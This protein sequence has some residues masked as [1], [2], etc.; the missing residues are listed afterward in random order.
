MSHFDR[1]LAEIHRMARADAIEHGCYPDRA[2]E[3]AVAAVRSTVEH[4]LNSPTPVDNPY[5]TFVDYS[6][7]TESILLDDVNEVM[8]EIRRDDTRAHIRGLVGEAIGRDATTVLVKPADFDK[9]VA[10]HRDFR[11]ARARRQVHN[12]TTVSPMI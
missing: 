7:L 10:A 8:L 2:D 9:V 4:V 5:M 6:C 11:R 1:R 12:L 3:A